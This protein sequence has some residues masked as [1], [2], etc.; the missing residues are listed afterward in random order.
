MWAAIY[1]LHKRQQIVSQ[2]SP[3]INP[4]SMKLYSTVTSPRI[5]Q[6]TFTA[7]TALDYTTTSTTTRLSGL[8]QG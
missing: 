6:F 3:V 5:E 7:V 4:L 1:R 8:A 2:L